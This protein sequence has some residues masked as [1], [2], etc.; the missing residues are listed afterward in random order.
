M[1]AAQKVVLIAESSTVWQNRIRYRFEQ[2]GFAVDIAS[3]FEEALHKLQH[4]NYDILTLDLTLGGDEQNAYGVLLL[5]EATRVCVELPPVMII[6]ESTHVGSIVE[7]WNYYPIF[8]HVIK[9][10]WAEL[11]RTGIR[12]AF[13][14]VKRAEKIGM[15]P[16]TS[17]AICKKTLFVSKSFHRSDKDVNEYIE[18]ILKSLKIN[19]ETG[20]PY[21]AGSIPESVKR[22]ISANEVFL[23]IWVHDREGDKIIPKR[24]R[25][26]LISE[27]EYAEGLNKPVILIVQKGISQFGIFGSDKRHITI[28]LTPSEVLI[29][30]TKELLEAITFHGLV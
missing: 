18:G 8:Y 30:A 5:A 11:T 12:E 7:A 19:Y 23:S 13:D 6:S 9:N 17:S 22:K 16:I 1:E 26:Y 28:A 14:R 29:K 20:E 21:T 24:T 15:I 27:T 3:T 4:R 2:E 25:T 10:K